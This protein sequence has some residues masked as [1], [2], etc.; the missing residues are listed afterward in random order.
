VK[1]INLRKEKAERNKAYAKKFAKSWEEQQEAKK[2]GKA[3]K[4]FGG[5]WG[6][7]CRVKGHPASCSCVYD[8]TPAPPRKK[9]K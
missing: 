2:R 6:R 1:K 3:E 8:T 4:Q 9:G 7:W 5:K